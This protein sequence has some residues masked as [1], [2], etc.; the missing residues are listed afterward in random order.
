[1]ES[2]SFHKLKPSLVKRYG[3]NTFFIPH[4]LED[5]FITIEEVEGENKIVIEMCNGPDLLGMISGFNTVEQAKQYAFKLA[6]AAG[7]DESIVDW[8]IYDAL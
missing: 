4:G 7:Y 6:K 5:M 2:L 3:C 8:D 1:M